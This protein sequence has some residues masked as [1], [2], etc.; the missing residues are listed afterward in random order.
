MV[1]DLRRQVKRLKEE[2][3][4]CK[5]DLLVAEDGLAMAR[6]TV[7]DMQASLQSG[8]GKLVLEAS[9]IE[10]QLNCEICTGRLWLP[11]ILP[12]CGHVFCQ[13]CL[14]EWFDTTLAHFLAIHPHYNVNLMRHLQGFP[15][16]PQ[17]IAYQAPQYTCPTCRTAVRNRPV[18]VFALKALVR[19]IAAAAGESSPKKSPPVMNTRAGK[20]RVQGAQTAG[21]WDKFFPKHM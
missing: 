14:E 12:E 4:R 9:H 21:P 11:H 13:N 18:E 6:E 10:D 17:A 2:N 8:E 7:S 3:A 15:H 20:S 5:Q 16:M 1:T 19:T